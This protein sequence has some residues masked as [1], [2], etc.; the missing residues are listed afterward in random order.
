MKVFSAQDRNHFSNELNE[1]LLLLATRSTRLL[2]SVTVQNGLNL[3]S[4]FAMNLISFYPSDV[5]GGLRNR[6]FKPSRSV[7]SILRVM[8]RFSTR[9]IHCDDREDATGTVTVPIY[10]VS[11]FRQK[12]PG[13]EGEY[14]YARTANPTRTALETALA[15]LEEG[16]HGLAFGS[17]M[18][19]ITS[20]ALSLL[21]QGDHVVAVQDLYGGSRRL[22]DRIMRNFGVNFT[23]VQGSSAR[24]FEEAMR[25]ETK[26]VWVESPT[27]PLLQIVDIAIT[28]EV[29]H[30]RNALL[31]VDNTFASP[32]LQEPLKFGADIVIHSTTKYLGGHSDL[33]GGA[34]VLSDSS[35]YNKVR[36]AQ[37]AA[38]AVPGPFDC[39]LVLR[40]IKTLAVRMDRHCSNAQ[41]IAEYLSSHP[42]IEKVLYPGLASH[43]QHSLAAK[44][45]AEF[46]GM[47]SI[48]LK[49]GFEACRRMLNHVKIFTL[50]E[51]L[52]AV[53]S[54]IEHPA[55]MTHS[56]VPK[57]ER[58][59]AGVSDSLIRLSVGIEDV[60][61]LVTD[62][63][64]ALEH[65]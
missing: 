36:F 56:S 28:A 31:V 16:K 17:G 49:G 37:N 21:R 19:A 60:E 52:G 46:G 35:I 2:T 24:A 26:I 33:I 50:A 57:E 51:S 34:V 43:P 61:D 14:V 7:S 29:A 55:S 15:A 48:Y 59:R 38:G 20:L 62:L 6:T 25:P 13:L 32:Y 9:A 53:E 44:Q 12:Q 8:V 27:N 23:Y 42:K 3:F 41:R 5:N 63:S 1:D 45:M 22:F 39:W 4:S 10:Q 47:V 11:T 64:Q 40:G 58:E 18:G 30:E 65:V 54:L